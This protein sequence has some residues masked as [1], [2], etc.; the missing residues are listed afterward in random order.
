MHLLDDV[1]EYGGRQRGT[2]AAE[3]VAIDDLLARQRAG[4]MSIEQAVIEFAGERGV[5]RP[6]PLVTRY[7]ALALSMV[8]SFVVPEPGAREVCGRLEKLGIA[9][10]VLS[11]GWNPLQRAKVAAIGF[12]GPLLVS[13]ELGASKP[14]PQAFEALVRELRVPP[15]ACW[16]V[17]D[18][19]RA[20]V[21]GALA[22]GLRAVWMDV[23]NA[24]YPTGLPKPTA[25]IHSLGEL[26]QVIQGAPTAP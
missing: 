23:Q 15:S 24:A 5:A 10:A 22:A 2:L 11:N 6:E 25:S 26:A 17:G 9:T 4:A 3:T 18:D 16:Y 7:K 19:P 12:A 13:A 21:A 8:D 14:A 20:D 1:R